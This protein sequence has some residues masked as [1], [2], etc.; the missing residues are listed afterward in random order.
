MRLSNRR[1]KSPDPEFEAKQLVILGLYLDLPDNALI[2]A[3]DAKSHMQALDHQQF[4]LP[5]R[6]GYSH[7]RTA[8][9]RRC[10]TTCL[11]AA[12]LEHLGRR[13]GQR[14]ESPH[15]PRIL[16]VSQLSL[17]PSPPPAFTRDFNNFAAHQHHKV[18]Q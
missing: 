17:T 15:P 11:V 12:W 18:K 14:S 4:K 3:V 7:R 8:T 9:Y 10:G 2:L 13:R 16:G 5:S 1:G 6:A